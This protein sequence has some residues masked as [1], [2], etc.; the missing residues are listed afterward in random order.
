MIDGQPVFSTIEEAEAHA[1]TLGCSGYHE[2]EYEGRT[3]YM[4]CEGHQ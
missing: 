1:K 3:A 4:A 2:H